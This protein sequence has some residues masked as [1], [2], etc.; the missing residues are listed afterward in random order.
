M[1]DG[2]EENKWQMFDGA[3][4]TGALNEQRDDDGWHFSPHRSLVHLS[5]IRGG[6]GVAVQ[7][8][9]RKSKIFTDL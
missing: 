9:V 6:G 7:N 1:P 4:R 3:L 2:E 8:G 5:S